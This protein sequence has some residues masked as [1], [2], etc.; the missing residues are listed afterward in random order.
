MSDISTETLKML[1]RQVESAIELAEAGNMRP[2]DGESLWAKLP[3]HLHYHFVIGDF[4][5]DVLPIGY[6]R[7]T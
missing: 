2:I 5:I 1:K 6:P 7:P 3:E 4:G